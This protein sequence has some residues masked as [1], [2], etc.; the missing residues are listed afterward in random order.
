M[1]A[2]T[3]ASRVM[4]PLLRQLR[5]AL[6][7]ATAPASASSLLPSPTHAAASRAHCRRSFGS[8]HTI[9]VPALG[10]SISEGTL[11]EVLLAEGSGVRVD[12]V[13]GRLDTDK[14]S[15][16]LRSDAEGRITRWNFKQGDSVPVGAKLLEVEVGAAGSATPGKG[17]VKPAAPGQHPH[18]KPDTEDGRQQQKVPMAQ[19]GTQSPVCIHPTDPAD[20]PHRVPLIAFR[21]GKRA[22]KPA[23]AT[24]ATQNNQ[25]APVAAGDFMG[26]NER[27]A[28]A[29]EE[30][31]MRYKRSALKEMQLAMIEL[32]GAPDYEPKKKS[33]A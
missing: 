8:M 33:R 9:T 22:A 29:W 17:G 27:A 6:S 1:L 28:K 11:A 2:A 25:T 32:G 4:H 10:D 26:D 5:P 31:P 16:D 13:V 21:Y 14:V 20:A 3:R 24:A 19:S 12:D 7:H 15:I 30:L 18:S 23:P